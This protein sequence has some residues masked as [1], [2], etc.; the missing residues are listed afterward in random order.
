MMKDVSKNIL[1]IWLV[2][3]YCQQFSVSNPVAAGDAVR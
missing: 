2:D 3:R 1:E